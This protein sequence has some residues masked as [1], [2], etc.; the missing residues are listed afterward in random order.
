MPKI[1]SSFLWLIVFG[2]ITLGITRALYPIQ[3]DKVVIVFSVKTIEPTT[4]NLVFT[5]NLQ[6]KRYRDTVKQTLAANQFF[7][8]LQ[9]MYSNLNDVESVDI[10]LGNTPGNTL[11]IEA[12]TLLRYHRSVTDTVYTWR[13]NDSLSKFIAATEGVTCIDQTSNY[14][15]LAT[16]PKKNI[17]HLSNALVRQMYNQDHAASWQLCLIALLLGGFIIITLSVPEHWQ[18]RFFFTIS[19]K[20]KSML[21][22]CFFGLIFLVFINSI[23][24]IIPDVENKENRTMTSFPSL[25]TDNFYSFPDEVSK[26]TSDHFAFRNFF[27]LLNSWIHTRLLRESAMPDKTIVG[28]DHWYFYN[29]QGSVEDYRRTTKMDTALVRYIISN[30]S[31]RMEWLRKRGIKYYF[32]VPP[33]KERIYPDYML[34]RYHPIDGIGHNSLD[35]CKKM[36]REMGNIKLIDPSEALLVKRRQRDVYYKNDTHWNTYGGFIGY[37]TLMQEISKDFPQLHVFQENE[38]TLQETSNH[39]GDLST[40]MGLNLID[41]RKEFVFQYKDTSRK[42]NYNVPPKMVLRYHNSLPASENH[43]L[44]LLMFRDSFGSYLIPFFNQQFNETVY[45]WNY[46]FMNRLIEEEKPDIVVFESLQRFLMYALLIPNPTA[47]N[48]SLTH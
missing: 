39:E 47:V 1:L 10:D 26:H 35:F 30:L 32:L 14:L 25:G 11:Y 45:A 4:F 17:L 19:L 9:F 34:G 48:Q 43:H 15:E 46:I 29:D 5:H 8:P 38:F 42:L 16:A 7:L 3:N 18:E 31:V 44:K 22:P 6:G 40:M 2:L 24:R 21:I 20:P 36:L 23:V 28:H 27:F 33:N 13:C 37:Q 41:Q 12:L